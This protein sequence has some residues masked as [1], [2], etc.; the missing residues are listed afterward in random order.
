MYERE[1]GDGAYNTKQREHT[2]AR[3]ER[4]GEGGST[5]KREVYST[6]EKEI[7]ISLILERAAISSSRAGP[8]R[9][10]QEK[11][12]EVLVATPHVEVDID[13]SASF[14]LQ[15]D[16]FSTHLLCSP[17]HPSSPP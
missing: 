7:F 9:E 16:S 13:N 14:H 10:L 17:V 2:I 5:R 11:A 4:G 3:R 6:R 12:A 8:K 15:R 1:W